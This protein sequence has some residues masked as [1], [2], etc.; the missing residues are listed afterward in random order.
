M[1]K[2]EGGK[3]REWDELVFPILECIANNR[4][5]SRT[6]LRKIT[7]GDETI[8]RILS[9]WSEVGAIELKKDPLG[10]LDAWESSITKFGRQIL[11]N[12]GFKIKR[13]FLKSKKYNPLEISDMEKLNGLFLGAKRQGHIP[14]KYGRIAKLTE[15]WIGNHTHGQKTILLDISKKILKIMDEL[16]EQSVF[17]TREYM[18]YYYGLEATIEEL[19]KELY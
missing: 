10:E 7:K 12:A 19:E 17:Q 6:K 4:D 1:A 8:K 13:K 3:R 15:Q 9:F 18:D 16:K 5:V 2:K 11:V 14:E